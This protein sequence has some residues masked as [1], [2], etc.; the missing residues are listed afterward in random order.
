MI[1]KGLDPAYILETYRTNLALGWPVD[2]ETLLD[3]AQKLYDLVP[4]YAA[5]KMQR[6]ALDLLETFCRDKL[7]KVRDGLTDLAVQFDKNPGRALS[8]WR[9]KVDRLIRIVNKELED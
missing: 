6:D 5:L 2:V 3:V 1:T 9:N 4:D 8:S 7:D